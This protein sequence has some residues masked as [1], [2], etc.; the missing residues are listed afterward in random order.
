MDRS[1]LVD[2]ILS[3]LKKTKHYK[4]LYKN[5]V[6][7]W[8]DI[9]RFPAVS[10]L[11]ESEERES[12]NMNSTRSYFTGNVLIYVFNKQASANSYKDILS[13]LINDVY[14]ITDNNKYIRC[15]TISCTASNMKREGGIIHPYS[16]AQIT[17][18]VRFTKNT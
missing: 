4:N 5:I 3:D 10:V 11:Y 2:N 1:L 13:E 17:I 8:T 9:P 15:N 7:V 14:K 16:I 18:Q 12:G 6:P